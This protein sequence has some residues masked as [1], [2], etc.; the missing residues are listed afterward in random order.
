MI[1]QLASQITDFGPYCENSKVL[2]ACSGGADSTFLAH[3]YRHIAQSC[4]LPPAII[5]VI[6]HAQHPD[7]E[8]LTST[9]AASYREHGF[10]VLTTLINCDSNLNENDMRNHR[11]QAL[12][13][14][15]KSVGAA[16]I[17]VAHHGDDQA[18]TILQRIMRGTGING[19]AGMPKRRVL[20]DG[21]E[22]CRPLL[23]LRRD[24][25]REYLEANDI[26]WY[27]DLTNLDVSYA[28]RNKIRHH[29]LPQLAEVSTG[30]PVKALVKL[31]AEAADWQ[32]AQRELLARGDDFIELPS[33]IRRQAIR[34]ELQRL[35]EKVTPQRLSDIESALMKKGSAVI[36][37]TLRF[38]TSGKK[39]LVVARR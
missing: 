9:I 13:Q 29:V 10:E 6:D 14:M 2:L 26:E 18:E 19:L 24:E 39:L 35:E 8:S 16:Q 5:A 28:T 12:Q 34:A 32:V 25:I 20:N 30:D 4:D 17:F 23:G 37:T 1:A 27:E 15:A 36:N 3:A 31:A 7:S 11:Y 21:V 33:Y 22:L 38:S